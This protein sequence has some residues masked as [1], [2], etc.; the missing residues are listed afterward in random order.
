MEFPVFWHENNE[1][2]SELWPKNNRTFKVRF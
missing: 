1:G 2:D